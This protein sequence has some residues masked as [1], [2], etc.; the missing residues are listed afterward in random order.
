MTNDRKGDITLF[1]A[2][3]VSSIFIC[4][5]KNSCIPQFHAVRILSDYTQPLKIDRP[6]DVQILLKRLGGLKERN[7][8]FD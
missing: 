1:R 6:Q 3:Q 2:S 4:L 5:D 8:K 7:R